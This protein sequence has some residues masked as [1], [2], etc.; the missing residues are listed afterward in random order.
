M[1]KF[2]GILR[3]RKAF[4][5]P[6]ISG[7]L[8]FVPGVVAGLMLVGSTAAYAK[9]PFSACESRLAS[10]PGTDEIS[11][12]YF[13]T[14]Q[15]EDQRKAALVHIES[16]QR[17]FP[18][19]HYLGLA[20]GY[21]LRHAKPELAL[22]TYAKTADKFAQAGDATGQAL[23]QVARVEKLNNLGRLDELRALLPELAQLAEKIPSE[24]WRV[25]T[26]VKVLSYR[27]SFN[28][29]VGRSYEAIMQIERPTKLPSSWWALAEL[30]YVRGSMA[31]Q[32]LD[33]DRA[34]EDYNELLRVVEPRN[35]VTKIALAHL[36]L[37]MLQYDKLRLDPQP[38][39]YQG[40]VQAFETALRHNA[41]IGFTTGQAY[42]S[43]YYA[44]LLAGMEELEEAAPPRSR[45]KSL[46]PNDKAL[47]V[48]DR[49]CLSV[50]SPDEDP[51]G[52]GV[53]LAV[54]SQLLARENK[55]AAL[56]SSA[57]ALELLAQ[58]GDQGRRILGW[59]YLMRRFWE[60][61][62]RSAAKRVAM[63]ALEAIETL[64]T[65]QTSLR[66]RRRIFASTT[67]DYYWLASR[68]L[69][70][71]NPDEL[72]DAYF[73]IERA[74]ARVLQELLSG[75]TPS[76]S[77]RE[78]R[79]AKLSRL[80]KET[81]AWVVSDSDQARRSDGSRSSRSSFGSDEK[82]HQVPPLAKIQALLDPGEVILSYQ[83]GPDR[84]LD[85]E[86]MGGS[87]ALIIS[88]QG[89]QA[90]KLSDDRQQLDA[91]CRLYRS[92]IRQR[93]LAQTSMA[94][95]IGS[96]VL[97]P[98]LKLLPRDT[99]EVVVVP[100]GPLH[101]LSWASLD[102]DLDFS[103]SPSISIWAKIRAERGEPLPARGL[104]IVDPERARQLPSLPR[105][106]NRLSWEEETLAKAGALP[107]SQLEK[108][109]IQ[110]HLGDQIRACSGR[111]ATKASFQA[112]WRPEHSFLHLSAHS[113]VNVQEPERSSIV[114]ADETHDNGLWSTNDIAE[115]PMQHA[116]VVL[117]GCSTGWGANVVGEG[118]LSIAR[119]FQRAGAK[120]VVASLWPVRDDETAMFFTRFY[121]ALGQG[122]PV[123]EAISQTQRWMKGRDLPA[124]AYA[125]FVVMGD[126]SVRFAAQEGSSFFAKAIR[127]V[128]PSAFAVGVVLFLRRKR[129]G[130]SNPRD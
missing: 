27:V 12:C 6:D 16:M 42:L 71:S 84:S 62:P 69:E 43:A 35:E 24:T 89:A 18:E 64:R 126:A 49:H 130:V 98:V 20:K 97:D 106:G 33:F 121:E 45:T 7:V 83:V 125:G 46:R 39:G 124:A 103:V 44:S 74:R 77:A 37:A 67:S 41:A 31:R 13:E 119:A 76:K 1:H 105:W 4:A 100:D 25:Y 117:G 63:T 111:D 51:E 8:R 109:A 127:F 90:V 102:T 118:V 104:V 10:T 11:L 95:S 79:A 80:E 72:Q 65:L 82:G 101:G 47:S 85:G 108:D 23:C 86:A 112:S 61:R 110:E 29:D 48:L 14:A 99:R 38:R 70:G 73:V 81:L 92:S 93:S 116:M 19:E 96:I 21:M 91:K 9:N 122:L 68:F 88:A 28:I 59:R 60:Q 94:K 120:S 53:C 87:W 5:V 78:F 34:E 114:L 129:R 22:E 40:A 15:S 58:S 17:R 54:R 36:G 50:S 56:D 113:I 26:Q 2:P 57:Q 66:A 3:F 55:Q 75:R 52:L 128:L 123:G 30:L 115:Q 32:L 107:Y